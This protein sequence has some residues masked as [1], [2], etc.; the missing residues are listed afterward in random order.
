M[1]EILIF[2]SSENRTCGIISLMIFVVFVQNKSIDLLP[3]VQ[4]LE[5]KSVKPN[6]IGPLG[7]TDLGFHKETTDSSHSPKLLTISSAKPSAVLHPDRQRGNPSISDALVKYSSNPLNG[8]LPASNGFSVESYHY[9]AVELSTQKPPDSPVTPVEWKLRSVAPGT[10]L[11]G[12]YAIG[13]TEKSKFSFPWGVVQADA[14]S[15]S[16]R[17]GYRSDLFGSSEQD[18]KKDALFR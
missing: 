18:K 10:R 8:G 2:H 3:E 4:R 15:A 13:S 12:E 14:I 16:S 11:R 1:L 5:L 6:E 9:P 17:R 7:A